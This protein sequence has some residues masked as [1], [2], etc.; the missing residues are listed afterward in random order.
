MKN[1]L[2]SRDAYIDQLLMFKDRPVIKVLVGVRR[3]GKSTLMKM[4]RE[5]LITT[6]VDK[7]NVL[8]FNFTHPPFSEASADEISK[9]ARR[10]KGRTYLLLDEVQM[11]EH[12]D[13]MVLD[14]FENEDCDIY[15]TGSNSAMFS[16][17]LSTLLSGRAVTI[18]I[19]PFSY[20]EFLR[21]TEASE[22]EE[23]LTE[24]MEYGGFPTS[25]MLRDSPSAR[26]VVLEDIYSTV[27]LKDII[28]RQ[29][30]RNQQTLD[31]ISRFLARS[32]GNLVSVKS[33]RDHMTSSGNKV[34][35]ETI[36]SYLGYLEESSAFYRVK[37]YNIKAKEELI[38]NDKFYLADTGLRTAILGRR[39]ADTGQVMENLVFLELR[40][41]RY[42]IHVGKLE[43]NEI[44][45]VA[46]DGE[47]KI[48]I[49]VCYSLKDPVTEEREV[50][51]LRLIG[52]DYRKVLI[53]MERSLKK[54]REG[55]TE[56]SLREFLTGAPL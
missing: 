19:F 41:R 1:R 22:T 20:A 53:V 6:G 13:K 39:G 49:Q 36:D 54:D 3:C 7:N 16:S 4:Y 47:R 21:F 8:M 9:E 31:R 24:Y 11:L 26:S 40:R 45:F 42:K 32:I 23:A 12:W 34:N 43:D 30:I 37:R 15:V 38:V 50:R 35:F 28:Q 46:A 52:D 51:P 33:I 25:L 27:V 17:R 10:R 55:I 44:D 18:E 5:H 56:I 48:Y 2:I 14:L 29:N